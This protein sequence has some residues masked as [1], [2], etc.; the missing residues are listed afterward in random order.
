MNKQDLSNICI[1]AI[2]G[3]GEKDTQSNTTNTN[4]NEN[5]NNFKTISALDFDKGVLFR[6]RRS[7]RDSVGGATVCCNQCCSI[8]GYASL[9]EPDS[10]RLLK[11]RLCAKEE[12]KKSSNTSDTETIDYFA[13]NTCSTFIACELTRYAESQAVFTFMIF[14]GDSNGKILLLKLLSW[15]T[16]MVI[17]KRKEN[18][19]EDQEQENQFE[20]VAKVIY[21]EIDNPSHNLFTSDNSDVQDPMNFTWG[22]LD[23]CCPPTDQ[24]VSNQ[25][26]T[27]NKDGEAVI[28]SESTACVEIH[29]PGDEWVQLK[30]ALCT[31]STFIP[32]EIAKV[33]IQLKLGNEEGRDSASMSVLQLSRATAYE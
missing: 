16:L 22:G 7:W 32:K 2:D 21:E 13:S 12:R 4:D 27:L 18:N 15:N 5:D 30:E 29:L 19:Y 33:T 6:G 8:L 31:G 26:S 1:L 14:N 23:L 11:H 9:E 3:Y 10:C 25:S 24:G 20:R 17:S 28:S